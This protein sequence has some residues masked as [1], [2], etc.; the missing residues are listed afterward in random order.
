MLDEAL[1]I[2]RDEEMLRRIVKFIVIL[3][4]CYIMSSIGLMGW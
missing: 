4:N 1:M 2:L 3:K